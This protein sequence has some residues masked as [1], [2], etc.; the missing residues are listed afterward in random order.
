MSAFF[1]ATNGLLYRNPT[2]RGE[3][4]LLIFDGEDEPELLIAV[5]SG[6]DSEG[7]PAKLDAT[8]ARL[9]AVSIVEQS[10]ISAMLAG[11]PRLMMRAYD[12]E[13]AETRDSYCFWL[14]VAAPI[15]A[16]L[17]S[18]EVGVTAPAG[19]AVVISF[20]QPWGGSEL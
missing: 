7:N 13:G 11:P 6:R 17:V 2:I 20:G 1:L 8:A 12:P 19:D 16:E 15:P 18:E 3:G 10:G 4:W 5:D 14:D 9:R